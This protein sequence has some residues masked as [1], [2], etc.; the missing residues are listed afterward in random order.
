MSLLEAI[1]N[2]RSTR[3]FASDPI[4]SETLSTILDAAT[5]A[6]SAGNCQPWRFVVIQ[7][8]HSKQALAEAA[9]G[10]KFVAQAAVVIVVC[11]DKA[12][13]GQIYGDRGEQ[14]YCI[15]DTAAAIQNI[16]LATQSLGLGACWVGAFNESMVALQ[17][18]APPQ[19]RPVA[20]V[21]I[22]KAAC[23]PT[24][25]SKVAPKDVTYLERFP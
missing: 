6:P 18:R 9:L 12:K 24:S 21:A 3:S 11:A 19:V 17:I 2:R 7:N 1:R 23:V 22:G 13:S 10:Q 14:L 16:L 8:K 25:P 20:L 5:Q 15:Q 4:E